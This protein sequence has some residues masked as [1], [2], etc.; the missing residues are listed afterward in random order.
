[1]P[2]RYPFPTVVLPATENRPVIE[3]PEWFGNEQSALHELLVVRELAEL[4]AEV[5]NGGFRVSQSTIVEYV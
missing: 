1:M 3:S 4:L 5:S 2:V